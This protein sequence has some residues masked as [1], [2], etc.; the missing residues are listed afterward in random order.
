MRLQRRGN[1]GG[2][3]KTMPHHAGDPGR[4]GR[5]C[6]DDAGDFLGQRPRVRLLGPRRIEAT[7]M[8]R[9]TT[10]RRRGRR[11][12]C[13]MRGV[14]RGEQK[15]GLRRVLDVHESIGGCEPR[16]DAGRSGCI[17]PSAENAQDDADSQASPAASRVSAVKASGIADRPTPY[18]PGRGGT[19]ARRG[20]DRDSRRP[21]P[22][23]LRAPR[24][25]PR[26]LRKAGEASRNRPDT[27]SVTSIRGR[28]SSAGR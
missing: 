17:A 8:V 20:D 16:L 14:I 19:R 7:A 12:A 1:L 4:I 28:P 24:R 11:D 3:A 22:R 2:T 5:A 15:I 9:R 21:P 23:A 18:W 6:A 13:F 10:R 25:R 27:R 26:T